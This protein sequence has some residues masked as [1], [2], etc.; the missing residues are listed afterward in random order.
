LSDSEEKLNSINEKKLLKQLHK[1]FHELI[2]NIQEGE[3][4]EELKNNFI[5]KSII[6]I[7]NSC[8][9]LE[10]TLNELALQIHEDSSQDSLENNVNDS[11]CHSREV[12]QLY[13]SG[14]L[15]SLRSSLRDKL[16]NN[17]IENTKSLNDVNANSRNMLNLT[18]DKSK[19]LKKWV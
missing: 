12:L 9:N 10:P 17:N 1:S 7:R 3:N 15:I 8:E 5:N 13:N 11:N 6:S 4:I 16:Y 2:H 19:A 14:S 18:K